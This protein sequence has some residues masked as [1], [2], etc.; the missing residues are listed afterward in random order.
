MKTITN[1]QIFENVRKSGFI[2]E[3][4][5]NLI[6]NRSNKEGRD[7][8]DYNLL[9]EINDDYGVPVTPLQGAKALRWLQ[10]LIKRNGEPR[11]GQN[12]GCRE[13]DIINNATENDF[14]FINVDNFHII[15]SKI[16]RIVSTLFQ[17]YKMLFSKGNRFSS[18]F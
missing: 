5:I 14:T 18:T 10:S 17:F 12:L 3:R 13:I 6:K 11:E 15:F 9:D 16:N 7:L 1:A 8:L 2:S 4:E